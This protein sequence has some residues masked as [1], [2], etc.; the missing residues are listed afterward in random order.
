M[1]R[2]LI[3]AAIATTLAAPAIATADTKIY[4]N[5]R[6][7]LTTGDLNG[8]DNSAQVVNN[9][10]RLG[11]KGAI[12]ND[13]LKGI[14][15]L[16][17]GAN[18]DAGGEALSSR[19]YFAGLKGGFGKVIY[20]RLSTPYKMAGVKQDP[21]YDTSA[22]T[23]NGGSN[24]GYSSL[25]NSFT[26]NTIAYY[27][28]KIGGGV[29]FNASISIDDAASD[30][31]DYGIGAEYATKAFKVGVSH[32]ELGDTPVIAL[33]GGAES[34]TRIYASANV[35]AA[36]TVAASFESID[37]GT[38]DN[39]KFSHINGTFKV[40]PK[41]KLAASLSSVSDGATGAGRNSSSD[42]AAVG[43]FY[44]VLENTTLSAIYTTVDY[45]DNSVSDRDG[46]AFG[47]VQK[48]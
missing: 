14:Y 47:V 29:S 39:A 32:L 44:N 46:V 8:A 34:A 28:P 19:F 15:H 37:F 27:S 4:G 35:G 11:L 36:A 43:V 17:M 26:N 7:S 9:A 6:A 16:Q 33:N 40:S 23:S 48:F 22:G 25:N 3:V 1:K 41:V 30:D 2:T 21:F 20:G 10:S 42:G 18:N 31:H 5:F 45:D 24:H 12:G 38:A 13:D